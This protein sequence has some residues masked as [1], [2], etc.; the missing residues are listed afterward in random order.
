[1]SIVIGWK[2]TN[3]IA[4]YMIEISAVQVVARS[5]HEDIY[6]FLYSGGCMAGMH[7]WLGHLCHLFVHTTFCQLENGTEYE[8]LQ[9]L[10][11]NPYDLPL[12]NQRLLIQQL[13][14]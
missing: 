3:Q 7:T 13:F 12:L 1:M 14:D 6:R 8:D 11:N 10:C 9:Y 5:L 4:Q 2:S